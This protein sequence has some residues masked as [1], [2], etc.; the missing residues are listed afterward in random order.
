M[1]VDASG[2]EDGP[3]HGPDPAPLTDREATAERLLAASARHSYDPGTDVDWDAPLEPGGWFMPPELLSLHG[4]PLWDA[5]PHEQRLELSRHELSAWTSRG[6]WFEIILLQLLARHIYDKPFTSAHARYALTEIADECRHSLMF[7]RMLGKCGAPPYPVSRPLHQV[8]RAVKTCSSTP[9]SFSATL[10]GEEISDWMQRIT[11]RD[12]RVQP[13]VRE[14]FRI[15]VIEEARHVRYAREELRRL[16]A[17]QPRWRRT[18][19]ELNVTALALLLTDAY[20]RG[21]VYAAVGL[22]PAEAMRQAKASELRR[23]HMREATRKLTAFLHDIGLLTAASRPMW[24]R[25]GLLA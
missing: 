9:A 20:V 11:M 24:R 3:R 25:A 12:E 7:V 21:D 4:T 10:F 18:C 22:P 17:A 8:A 14:V 1:L 5:M 2:P 15:H 6:I 19:T 13:L 23:H 16:A